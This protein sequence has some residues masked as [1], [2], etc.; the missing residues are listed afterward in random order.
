MIIIKMYILHYYSQLHIS[1]PSKLVHDR[2]DNNV[3]ISQTH[4]YAEFEYLLGDTYW[5]TPLPQ[6]ITSP[7]NWSYN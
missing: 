3:G 4:S 6:L 7:I 1:A 2:S 5:V